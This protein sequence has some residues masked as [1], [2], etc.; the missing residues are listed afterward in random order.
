M[1]IKK[2]EAVELFRPAMYWVSHMGEE[3]RGVCRGYGIG[4]TRDTDELRA[5]KE[6]LEALFGTE[7]VQ[8]MG[9]FDELTMV[10]FEERCNAWVSVLLPM[11]EEGDERMT[12]ELEDVLFWCREIVESL[13]RVR[14]LLDKLDPEC[15]TD[16]YL[17]VMGAVYGGTL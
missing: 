4:Y 1:S 7:S 2:S 3:L 10:E 5:Y 12:P 11:F 16:S 6:Q 9:N 14:V 15:D 13:E 17:N 8:K